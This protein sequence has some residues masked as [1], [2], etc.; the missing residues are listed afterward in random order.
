MVG[1]VREEKMAGAGRNRREHKDMR[2]RG[3][4]RCDQRT[5]VD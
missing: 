1:K 3:G 4:G 5:A 2:S